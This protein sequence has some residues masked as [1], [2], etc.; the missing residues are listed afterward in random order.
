MFNPAAYSKIK[1]EIPKEVKI[2]AA[3]KSKPPR[4]IIEAVKA[5]IKLIG[6]NYVQEASEKYK[7]L[8]KL[9]EQESIEFH[10]IGH[11]QTNKVQEAIKIFDCIQ[12]LDSEKLAIKLDKECRRL[13]KKIKV[14]IEINFG[15]ESKSGIKLENLDKLIK[16]VRGLSNLNLVGL[17]S[18]PP[19]GKEETCFKKIQ[20]LKNQY[21]LQ[22]LSIGMS[23]DYLTAIK[24]GS[25]LIRL[26]TILFGER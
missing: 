5:G 17:M 25:T 11:L 26:G 18:I 21:N 3:T 7:L 8:N 24:N 10:L 13:N 2:L 20:E 6:E 12:T 19:I 4:D 9:F 1:S 16:R 23:S 22:E 15:E 14:M